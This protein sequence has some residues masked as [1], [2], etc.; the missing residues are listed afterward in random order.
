MNLKF[1]KVFSEIESLI[2]K[3]S[4]TVEQEYDLHSVL[5]EY[6]YVANSDNEDLMQLIKADSDFYNKI[7]QLYKIKKGLA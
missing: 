4:D 2:E 1:E 3:Y 5:V 7:K 6:D